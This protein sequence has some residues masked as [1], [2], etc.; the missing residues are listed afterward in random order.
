MRPRFDPSHRLRR[1]R[2]HPL[3]GRLAWT[4]FTRLAATLAGAAAVTVGLATPSFAVTTPGGFGGADLDTLS[5]MSTGD[6]LGGRAYLDRYSPTY[7]ASQAAPASPPKAAAGPQART[8]A[9]GAD[10]GTQRDGVEADGKRA[11]VPGKPGSEKVDGAKK[12][13]PDKKAVKK[14]VPV[15]RYEPSLPMTARTRGI[16]VAS[17]QGNV[18]WEYWWNQGKR[19]AYV[20][21]TEGTS[22]INPFF[23]Q[24]YNGSAKVGMLRGTYHFARPD[25]GNGAAQARFYVANGGGWTP[26]GKTLPGEL[27]IEYGEAVGVSTCYGVSQR[28]MVN[29]IRD[30][31]TTYK[32]LTGRAPAIYTTDDWWAQCT[33]DT[34]EFSDSPLWI[35]NYHDTPGRLPGG[36]GDGHTFW[37]YTDTPLD[38]NYFNGSLADL[39][40]FATQR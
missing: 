6:S 13:A 28:E 15:K 32:K 7:T 19:F 31:T 17:H 5:A 20:K 16:D 4:P 29:F 21:A 10:A 12:A 9:K 38:Q 39:R 1:L 14:A 36:W 27:D 18:D 3:R 11:A 2:S 30:F 24:Q 22:Y 40:R 35:A 23:G 26:D 37:Q 34:K 25:R 8:N 33:G